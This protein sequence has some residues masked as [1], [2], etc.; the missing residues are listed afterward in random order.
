MIPRLVVPG[1]NDEVARDSKDDYAIL[2]AFDN[3]SECASRQRLLCGTTEERRR[4]ERFGKAAAE[5]TGARHEFPLNPLV[6]LCLLLE[7]ME[8]A[9]AKGGRPGLALAS[10]CVQKCFCVFSCLSKR[11]SPSVVLSSVCVVVIVWG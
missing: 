10:R 11:A 3:E 4:N 8:K 1:R 7:H 5:R 2:Q 6:Y 9:K